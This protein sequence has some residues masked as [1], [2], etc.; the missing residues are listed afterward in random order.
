MIVYVS[1][2]S[3]FYSCFYLLEDKVLER[4][5]VFLA[6]ILMSKDGRFASILRLHSLVH[7]GAP[8][9]NLAAL[10]CITSSDSNCFS[11]KL[12]STTLKGIKPS[13]LKTLSVEC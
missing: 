6:F 4:M 8:N 7:I 10:L 2:S 5:N 12:F 1:I 11:C 9:I 13:Q 3:K